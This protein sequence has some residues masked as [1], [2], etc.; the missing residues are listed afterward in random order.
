VSALVSLVGAGPGDPDLLTLKAL[1]RLREADLVLYDALV[2][3]A[4]L[5]HA[6]QARRFYVGKRAG[7]HSMSQET[8][9]ALMVRAARR[10]QRVVRLKCGD[11]FVL[12]R[13]GEEALALVAAGIP[14]EVVPGVTSAVA[15]PGLAG[16]PVTHRGLASGFLVISGHAES[17]YEPVLEGLAPQSVT[18]VVLMGL[19]SRAAIASLLLERGW[20]G[21]TPAAVLMDASGEDAR[22]WTGTLAVLATAEDDQGDGPGTIVIGEVVSLASRLYGA[23]AAPGRLAAAQR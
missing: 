17:A 2:A 7:R 5:D 10:G 19:K 1:R 4:A 6:P 18:V 15:A 3:P 16:I 12:G 21:R 8:I 20:S 14:F 13:G 23:Q 9:N 11:P 22:T